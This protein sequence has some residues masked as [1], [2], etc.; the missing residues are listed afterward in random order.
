MDEMVSRLR[1]S[2]EEVFDVLGSGHSEATYHRAMERELSER[3]IPFS[4]ENTVPIIYKGTSVGRCRPDL[5]I[6]TDDGIVVV[7]L[8]ATDST[9]KEQLD[10]YL[11][12]LDFNTTFDI[13]GG[14][15]IRFNDS[16]EVI[17]A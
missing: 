11:N 4:S 8:K 3:G 6:T 10:N 7:E 16:V 14:V 2:A 1:D 5:F 13:V 15:L 17:E 9:G 12:I